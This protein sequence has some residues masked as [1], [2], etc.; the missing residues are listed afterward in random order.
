[1]YFQNFI[2]VSDLKDSNNGVLIKL[3]IV[4]ALVRFLLLRIEHEYSE[5]ITVL[6]WKVGAYKMNVLYYAVY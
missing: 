3:N 2:C 5:N 6:R 4:S 1:M